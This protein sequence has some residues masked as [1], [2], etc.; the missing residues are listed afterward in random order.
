MKPN[1]I[2]FIQ[3]NREYSRNLI[4][5]S[6]YHSNAIEGNTLS[7]GDT[8]AILWNDNDFKV[9]ARPRELYEAINYKYALSYLFDQI[10]KPLNQQMIKDIAIF[11]NKNI[12]EISGYR[13]GR[14]MIRGAEHIPPS[15]EEVPQRMMYLLYNIEKT[16]YP[17]VFERAADFHL[18]FERIHPFSDGNGR[19][20]RIMVD[21]FL[22]R[23]GEAP[24]VIPKDDRSRYFDYLAKQDSNGLASYFSELS[25]A[26]KE[27]MKNF[28]YMEKLPY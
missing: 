1:I 16:S 23:E 17:T 27:Q 9:Q 10:D 3:K 20:G 6:T 12:D 11:I 25:V 24:I 19:T 26:E 14:V 5:R 7:Y 22:L 13:T 15:P 8:Y 28:G 18:Q 2:N 4:T 21:Y